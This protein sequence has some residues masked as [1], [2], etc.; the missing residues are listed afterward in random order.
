MGVVSYLAEA[1]GVKQVGWREKITVRTP[2]P[3]ECA[4]FR[5]PDDGRIAVFETFRTSFDE[6]GT[7]LRLTITIY[8]ADRNEL[9]VNVG[10]VPAGNAHPPEANSKGA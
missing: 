3:N 6:S 5:L 9:C 8:P 1:L 2:G 10:N 4:F 7:P